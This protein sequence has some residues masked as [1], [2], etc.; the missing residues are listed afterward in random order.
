MR[1]LQHI[2]FDNKMHVCLC[3]Q[4]SIL[5]LLRVQGDPLRSPGKALRGQGTHFRGPREPLGA[6]GTPRG[7][8]YLLLD[9]F[10]SL[11]LGTGRRPTRYVAVY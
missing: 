3:A 2:S 7:Q 4:N 10:L 9:S 1:K 11:F 5:Y 8:G 6:K